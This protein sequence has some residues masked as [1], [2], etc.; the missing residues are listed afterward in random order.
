MTKA[1][2]KI[3][4]VVKNGI[5]GG[6]VGTVFGA[7]T[8][9]LSVAMCLTAPVSFPLVGMAAGITHDPMQHKGTSA[10]LGLTIGYAMLPTAPVGL[11][12]APFNAVQYGV[13]GTVIGGVVGLAEND[14]EEK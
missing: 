13:A 12:L 5:I 14:K 10:L 6:A 7:V 1:E 9:P 3:W 4:N 11:M 2:K 8:T